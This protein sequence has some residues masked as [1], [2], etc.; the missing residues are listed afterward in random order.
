MFALRAL[1]VVGLVIASVLIAPVTGASAG[2]PSSETR[3]EVLAPI[4]QAVGGPINAAEMS[5]DAGARRTIPLRPGGGRPGGGGGSTDGAAQTTTTASIADTTTVSSNFDGVGIGLGTFSVQY[6]PPDTNL[7]VGTTQVVQWVN[8]DWAVF[9]KTGGLL[10]GP[11]P[12]NKVWTDNGFSAGDCDTNNDGDPIVKF[13]AQ[14]RR[15]I[16]T[17][18]SVSGGPPYYVCL[19]VSTTDDILTTSWVLTAYDFGNEFPDYPK[20]GVWPDAYYMTFND[21]LNGQTFDGARACA[22]DRGALLNATT[23][24]MV[25]AAPAGAASLLPADLDG[26]TWAIGTTSAPPATR[27]G[28]FLQLGSNNL[29]IWEFEPDFA[30]PALSLVSGPTSIAVPAFTQACKGGTCVPQKGAG[31]RLDS[32][33]DRLMYRLAYRN[34]GD[35]ESLVV[36]HSVTGTGTAAPR[37]YELRATPAGSAFGPYQASSF[38]PDSTYRWMGSAA[39]DKLGDLAIGYSASSKAIYP[40]I[41]YTGRAVTDPANTLRAEATIQ[42]GGGSQSGFGLS[43]WGDYSSMAVDPGDDCT[44]WYTT[45]YLKSTG[46]WNWSTR[47]ASFKFA[48][49]N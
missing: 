34:F 19:A 23:A 3:F 47:I 13:D 45:E 29:T 20:L 17:Q 22:V 35:R 43:R 32:L 15:W 25:C 21:F 26:A 16:M 38:A 14:A 28:V 48:D 33:G 10:G 5:I 49:C 7:S 18:F 6:A 46:A 37:W 40:G 31:Q 4:A 12:G 39:M 24:Y 36:T 8:V 30:T 2:G 1:A 11:F 27:H 44:F 9:D 42:A 41:R